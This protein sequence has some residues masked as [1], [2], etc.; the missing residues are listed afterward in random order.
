M[1]R[2]RISHLFAFV[3]M[4]FIG[5]IMVFPLFWM[6]RSSVMTQSEIFRK[7]MQWLPERIQWKNYVD[8]MTL[9]PFARWICNSAFI[10]VFNVLGTMLT[11][12]MA[13]FA[14]ARLKF[15]G[16]NV[17][18]SMVLAAM[19]I[20]SATLLIPQF[21]IWKILHGIDTYAPLILGAFG[22]P[23]FY[24]FM[25]RQFYKGIPMDIDEAAKIDGAS[26]LRIYM[27]III[28]LSKAPLVTV[29]IFTFTNCWNDFMGPLIYLSSERKYTAALGLRSFIGM[30]TGQWHY[31]MA[32]STVLVIPVIILF[33]CC[34]KVFIGGI[35][36]SGGLKG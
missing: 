20:P 4:L 7:P 29:A 31:L 9:R 10:V 28:P 6:V 16:R 19:M 13:A 23:G 1:K 17:V 25:L 24:T 5:L 21:M 15:R 35:N 36:L 30:Y 11:C 27:N 3:L 33:A 34:Q 2:K 26:P 12:S 32:A 14:F 8:I 18:F 22:A